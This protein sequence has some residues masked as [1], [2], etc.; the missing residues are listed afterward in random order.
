MRV[1][2]AGVGVNP[3][4]KTP[5][6]ELEQ[7]PI[8]TLGILKSP[9][10]TASPVELI[11]MYS[12]T[13]SNVGVLPPAKI[14][15]VELEQA[16]KLNLSTLKSPKSIAFPVELIVMYSITLNLVNAGVGVTPAA[17]IPLVE[18]EQALKKALPTLKSPKS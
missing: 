15:L 11:V 14:P 3:P 18:L 12:I 10:S 16:L 17:K 5:L 7:A 2:G 9:K 4:P 1:A 8:E 6:V 13:L